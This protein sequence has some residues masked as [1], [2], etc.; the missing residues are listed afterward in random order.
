MIL[1]ADRR[2]VLNGIGVTPHEDVRP[3]RPQQV[4]GGVVELAHPV[5]RPAHAVEDVRIAGRE[6]QRLLDQLQAFRGA[7]R[8]INQRVPER[9]ERLRVVRLEFDQLGQA[10]LDF[11]EAIE[12]LAERPNFVSAAREI[13]TWGPTAVVA[14]QGKYGAAVFSR[15][16]TF[17][18]PAYPLQAVADP[19]GAGDTFAGGFVGYVAAQIAKGLNMMSMGQDPTYAGGPIA[20][21]RVITGSPV[22]LDS[23][24]TTS[25]FIV[26]RYDGVVWNAT[27][28][29]GVST[30]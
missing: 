30:G 18:L 22:D 27:T 23:G 17:A 5:E 25:N 8:A 3:E 24:V 20:D 4:A 21:G 19:T 10:R 14:K 11:V 15:E 28:L 13:L 6:R 29:G 1:R 9:V 2:V 16:D 7:R 12:L 26:Q